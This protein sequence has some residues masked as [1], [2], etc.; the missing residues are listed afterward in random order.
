MSMEL[1]DHPP[2][3]YMQPSGTKYS[4][5]MAL[6]ELTLNLLTKTHM[7]TFL[8][9]GPI[10]AMRYFRTGTQRNKIL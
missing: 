5:I 2:S 7:N 9:H 10:T 4:T 6:K 3:G 1:C 8:Q